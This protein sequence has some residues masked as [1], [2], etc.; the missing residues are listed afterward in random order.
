METTS[1]IKLF[2][3]FRS[4]NKILRPAENINV[5]AIVDQIAALFAAG[6]FYYFVF[7]LITLEFDYVSEGTKPLLGID[8]KNFSFIKYLNILHPEDQHQMRYKEST[9]LNLKLNVIPKQY[10]KNYKTVYLM[11]VKDKKGNYKIIL[12]QVKA[13]TISEDGK[14]QQTIGIHTDITYLKIPFDH[15]ISFLPIDSKLPIYHFEYLNNKYM[16]ATDDSNKF[17]R[18]ENDIIKLLGQGK[19]VNEI[20]DILYISKHTVN[21]H[22]KNIFKK[23]NCNNSAELVVKCLREGFM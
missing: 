20:A 3:V 2:D 5:F 10:I 6:S 19:R 7:N 16:L 21:T 17:T 14:I 9:S 12:H 23:S 15:K 13:L 22:K 8:P 4:Q 1:I 11:R 18:R